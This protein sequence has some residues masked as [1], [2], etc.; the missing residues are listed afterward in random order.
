M[1]IVLFHRDEFEP[2]TAH[3]LR[4]PVHDVR[5][6]H[7]L[8][9]L[10]REP[11]ETFRAGVVNGELGHA[12]IVRREKAMLRLRFH[13][14]SDAPD[15]Y[16]VTVLLGHPR[17]IQLQRILRDLAAIGVGNVVVT[18]T[19]LGERSYFQSNIWVGDGVERSLVE[20][21]AQG[22]NPRLPV[23][24]REHTLERAIDRIEMLEPRPSTRVVFDLCENA[25]RLAE[26]SDFT[27]PVVFAVGSERGW[28]A[29]ERALL[30]RAGY[31]SARCGLRVLR[32]ET[33]A[34]A[35]AALVLSRLG[36]M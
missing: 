24:V 21:A 36:I 30:A 26:L 20:G 22:G 10:R 28:S 1:N 27:P 5:T 16:P 19:E 34:V 2:G 18:H 4:L 33:A 32:T 6:K 25:A 23:V 29:G 17:P 8:E 3:E 13:P 35:A 9:V 14:E 31:R 12:E 11:H 7:I 15:S